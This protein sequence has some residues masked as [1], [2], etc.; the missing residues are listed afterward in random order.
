MFKKASQGCAFL[1]LE[2]DRAMIIL[3]KNIIAWKFETEHKRLGT[4]ASRQPKVRE[5]GANEREFFSRLREKSE[6]FVGPARL[7]GFGA[8]DAFE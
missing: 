6:N 2:E 1:L 3:C 7:P 8:L 4:L 5:T